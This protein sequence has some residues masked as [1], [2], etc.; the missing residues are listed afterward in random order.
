M[1]GYTM[2]YEENKVTLTRYYMKKD[3][4]SFPQKEEIV[5]IPIKGSE[6]WD[7]FVDGKINPDCW[8]ILS[9]SNCLNPPISA[10]GKDNFLPNEQYDLLSEEEYLE[11]L[12]I[13]KEKH[14]QVVESFSHMRK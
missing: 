1:N 10:L 9:W 8:R 5:Y 12:N 11:H 2:E 13:V 6:P 3:G 4:N 7:Y 14:K